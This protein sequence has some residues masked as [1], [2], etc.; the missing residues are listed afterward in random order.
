MNRMDDLL[1]KDCRKLF[2]RNYRID[3]NIGVHEHEKRAA[4]ILLINIE[5]YVPLAQTTPKRDD[6]SEVLDYDFMRET[7]KRRI[8]QGHIHLQETLCDDI[9]ILLM[10][11]A[12]VQAV[13][14]STE[15]PNVYPD[16]DAVGVEIFR[17]R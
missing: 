8:Q 11:N 14:V 1:L 4:Q 7:I 15:K 9:A 5:L 13:R 12:L 3:A 17:T 10:E 6:L 16:C 2:L